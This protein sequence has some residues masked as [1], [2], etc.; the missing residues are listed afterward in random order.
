MAKAEKKKK[1]LRKKPHWWSLAA[2]IDCLAGC[3][4][5]CLL[6]LAAVLLGHRLQSWSYALKIFLARRG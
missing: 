1:T 2:L 3:T 4:S 6:L 5:V